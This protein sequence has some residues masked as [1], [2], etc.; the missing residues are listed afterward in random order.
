MSLKKLF[1]HFFFRG[2]A[3]YTV[4]SAV[5]LTVIALLTKDNANASVEPLT[6]IYLLIFCYVTSFGSTVRRI[7]S[8]N[9]GVAWG[10][11][12]VCYIGGVLGFLA[13][14]SIPFTSALVA[15]AIFA[16]IYAAV[17]VFV[18]VSEKKK[19]GKKPLSLSHEG[20]D[21][22]AKSSV[23]NA[24]KGGKASKEKEPYQNMFS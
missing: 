24:K 1:L 9:Y 15:D 4:F 2:A 7:D 10:I 23:K 11:N 6:F 16:I 3:Y 14:C 21:Q 17:S 13:L 19:L 20:K 5:I 22:P 18:A 12:A 8:L